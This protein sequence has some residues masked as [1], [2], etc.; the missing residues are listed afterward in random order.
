MAQA[1]GVPLTAYCWFPFVDSLDW[2]S[3]LANAAGHI[4]PV[5]VYWLDEQLVRHES[6]MSRS[7]AAA[8]GGV[9][10][11]SLPAYRFCPPLT[12]WLRGFLPQMRHWDWREPPAE[13]V[14]RGRRG[15]GTDSHF[16]GARGLAS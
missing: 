7:Y 12:D 8:A 3:L 14:G 6:S 16:Q 15:T 9:P 13:E 10:S 2:D 1:A 4:D 11:A 5:G